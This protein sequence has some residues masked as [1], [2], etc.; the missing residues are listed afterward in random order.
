MP[1]KS[2]V[3]ADRLRPP[4]W[5]AARPYGASRSLVLLKWACPA[6]KMRLKWRWCARRGVRCDPLSSN[7]FQENPMRI[8]SM[9]AVLACCFLTTADQSLAQLGPKGQPSAAGQVLS[10]ITP[11][12]LAAALTQA[13]FR[14]QVTTSNNE[15][16]VKSTMHGFNVTVILK[17]CNNQG[18]GN[19]GF[20]TWFGDKVNLD[21]VNAWNNQW[22]FGKASID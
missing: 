21:F 19:Y 14:S 22:R 13:G 20:V 10:R 1:I 6:K 16:Y 12:Q 2:T 11:E 17:D 3:A 18:C 4:S 15:K 9:I 8:P 7:S 5:P